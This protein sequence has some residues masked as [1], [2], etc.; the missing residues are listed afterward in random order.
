MERP[1][2]TTKFRYPAPGH[3]LRYLRLAYDG[4]RDDIV[5]GLLPALPDLCDP[6][7]AMRLGAVAVLVDYAAGMLA[8]K[9]VHPDWTVT[10][11]MAVHLTG[12][13]PPGGE[14]ACTC[15]PVRVGRNN[16]LSEAT[17]AAPDGREVLRAYVT[18]TRLPRREGTPASSNTMRVNLAEEGERPRQPLDEVVGYRFSG[19]NGGGPEGCHWVEFDHGPFTFNSLGA[20]QGGVVALTIER[21]ISWAGEQELGRPCRTVDL[22]LHYLALGRNGP[23]QA[24]AEV[25]RRGE[26]EVVS[27]VALVDTG[28]GDRLLALGVGTAHPL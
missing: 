5:E 26:H 13:A 11:D 27:R 23:F 12:L 20:I 18:F 3:I 6:A 7:G 15:R 8:L 24:R 22:H 14:L 28:N 10:H 2:E 21:G 17:V 19:G 9:T 4:T 25:L 16:V 1:A